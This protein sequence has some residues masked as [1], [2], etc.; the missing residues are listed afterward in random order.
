[1]TTLHALENHSEFH[2]R[3]IGPSDGEIAEM[4]KVVGSAS[5]DAL[6]DAIVP[7]SIKL[8]APL[9]LPAPMTEE[10]ALARIRTIADGNRVYRSFIGQ[11]YSGTL[12]PKVI[13]RNILE[14]PAWYTAYT[15]YQAEISQG[16][17]E[18]LINFQTMIADLT[19]M[20]IANASLLD[21]GTAAAE[22]MTLAKRSAKCR[23]NVFIVAGDCH[24]Q[25]IEV[26]RTRAEPL[27]IEVKVG[28]APE[29]MKSG[30]YFG[31]LAQYPATD[32]LIHD[33]RPFVEQ[34]HAAGALFCVAADLL[35][36]TLLEAP[37]KWG[38][39][40]GT[41]AQNAD[42]VIGNS[43]RFGVPFGFGGPHAAFLA[44][45]DA[46][47]RSMPGRLV[48][49]SV[50]SQGQPAYRLTLQTREQHIRREKATSNICTAQVL[51]AVMASM[52]AVYHGPDGLA[53]I[54]RRVHRLT[55]ILAEG[56]RRVGLQVNGS[57]FDTITVRGVDAAKVHAAARAAG[58]NLREYSA[59]DFGTL[60]GQIV[61]IALD[62]TVTRADVEALWKLF[63]V[64]ADI[65]ALDREIDAAHEAAIPAGLRRTTP[66][67]THPV[68]NA[69]HSEH[70]MLRYMR[71]LADKDLAL[72]RTMIPLGSCTM[73]LN[74]TSEMIPVTWPEFANIHPL[75]P[76]DQSAGYRQ[77]ITE[78][79]QML[80][81]C[82][83]YDA[84][85]L[86]PNSGAQGEYA[87]LLAIRAYHRSRGEGHR[88]ICLIPE[89]A[90]GT[91][92][93]SAQLCGMEVVAVKT[94]RNGNVDVADL[95]AKATQHAANLAALMVTYP[96][97][98]GVFEEAIVEICEV[99][100]AHGGQVY[101]DGANLN[102]LVGLAK[103]GKYGSDV[104]HLNLH[105]TFCIPH[106]GGGPGV[107]PVAVKS[108]LAPFL[109]G[110]LGRDN[111]VGM[112]SA[113][114]FG[115]ASILPISWMYIT[116]MG[117]AGLRKATQV[118]LLNANYVAKRLAP[119]YPT[120]YAGRNGF[121]AHECILDLR[122]LKD[123]SGISAEDVAKRLMD[124]GFHAPTLSFPV[125]GTLMVEP[126]ESEPKGEL[127]RFI[128]AM[129]AIREEIRAVEEGKVD[130]DDNPLKNAPHTAAMVMA[131]NW[132]HDYTRER[133]A[134]PIASLKRQ[135]YWPPV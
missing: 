87:G 43:Q 90:H 93:A 55:S 85:S 28:F 34:A 17:M 75:A 83:G 80:V 47:K 63:G 86:Q 48:G 132:A 49:V 101:T 106:G 53:R 33:M 92:P 115:S 120:L 20:E 104:S 76:A 91:N 66:F 124:Y 15:P 21:E 103:P 46:F 133:A 69:H 6:V 35:A 109:P 54:A 107:G 74:A 108:H 41:E 4:L 127:D 112:V 62:E 129:I 57:Y 88:N 79:E 65:D 23:S 102:A 1:M 131:E 39:A 11:G 25:T 58:I 100:H 18:A 56:L 94:D 36:L 2:A 78:L 113:A 19:G 71:S 128:D 14:N 123:A 110:H 72:D 26:I 64:A 114:N 97:T 52:Y 126:T 130:R 73:K 59:R 60:A 38:A 125:A 16:R 70:E 67:L 27:G 68:F 134:F 45:K 122:P 5:L 61:G 81:E 77:L 40:A 50:D 96:S 116:M 12:T 44:C 111:K 13:L 117:A 10:E 8:G 105:K 22:A 89:S 29:L 32:G 135:K 30:D 118:A 3:H 42:I 9:A 119:H 7:A 99:I 51:L 84:V 31:V 121:V 24:P 37:G 95:R 98:H 82:T